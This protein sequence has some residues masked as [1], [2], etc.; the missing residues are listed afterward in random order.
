MS[1]GLL[2]RG[3]EASPVILLQRVSEPSRPAQG[4]I[5]Q[6]SF[7]EA[8]PAHPKP[9][10][11]QVPSCPVLSWRRE[12]GREEAG[13]MGQGEEELMQPPV[14][15]VRPFL[16][17][18]CAPWEGEGG[19]RFRAAPSSQSLSRSTWGSGC[20]ANGQLLQGLP[21]PRCPHPMYFT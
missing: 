12:N 20:Q 9:D 14:P 4:A 3:L 13:E 10:W 16:G 1:L 21:F 17:A 6:T 2:R 5:A 18:P 8:L 7:G 11:S 19:R 15:G